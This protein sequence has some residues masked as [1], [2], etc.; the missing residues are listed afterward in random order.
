MKKKKRFDYIYL[1]ST[2][3]GPLCKVRSYVKA[4]RYIDKNF[5]TSIITLFISKMSIKTSKTRKRHLQHNISKPKSKLIIL[6]QF[7]KIKKI[8]TL[9]IENLF[10]REKKTKHKTAI[11]RF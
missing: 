11:K 3:M 4:L 5:K 2:Y 8:K 9:T 7:P 10:F 6:S 1:H